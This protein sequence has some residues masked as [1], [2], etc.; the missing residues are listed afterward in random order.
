MFR[1]SN[2][3]DEDIRKMVA[4]SKKIYKISEKKNSQ[5][6]LI[7]DEYILKK[8]VCRIIKNEVFFINKYKNIIPCEEIVNYK[9]G[10][11]YIIYKFV[12]NNPSN[13]NKISIKEYLKN[14]IKLVSNYKSTEIKG[15]GRI[16]ELCD[17]WKS[18]LEKEIEDKEKNLEI[19]KEKKMKVNRC[20]N[21]INKYEF[22]KKLLHGDLGFY[23]IIFNKKNIEL[24]I[25]PFPIIG[26]PLYDIIFFLFSRI[27]FT[28]LVQFEE[29]EK[30]MEE[31]KEKIRAMI[32]IQLYIR[33]LIEKKNN[34]DTVK[35]YEK[36]WRELEKSMHI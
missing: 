26:D 27:K 3:K 8:D 19:D 12:K 13:L 29:L 28:K 18:F 14:V 36:I 20:I 15:Y 9:N 6:Y 17:T 4:R 11:E 22:Q 2:L 33:I 24:L 23:N 7:N 16:S 35:E 34:R 32:Y 25:D 10:G 1:L 21:V 5:V 30:E 31:E